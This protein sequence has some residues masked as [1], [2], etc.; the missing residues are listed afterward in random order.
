MS[1]VFTLTALLT[2]PCLVPPCVFQLK[3]R[4]AYGSSMYT[5]PRNS[6]AI[7]YSPYF[8]LLVTD[9][10]KHRRCGSKGSEP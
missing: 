8:C 10:V 6:S 1:A 7:K 4:R 2:P 5:P 3:Y 9:D